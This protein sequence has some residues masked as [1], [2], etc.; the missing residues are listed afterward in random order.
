VDRAR[1][2][3]KREVEV[4]KLIASGLTNTEIANALFNSK[5]TIE[6]HRRN[7]I[8]KTGTRNTAELIRYA[9]KNGL[10]D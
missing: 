1:N 7:L 5:R 6:S 2:I 3:S 9:I 10:I 8:E 4:L